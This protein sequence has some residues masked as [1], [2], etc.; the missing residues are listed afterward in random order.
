MIQRYVLLPIQ[1]L[2]LLHLN[3]TKK[4]KYLITLSLLPQY[5]GLLFLKKNPG[6]VEQYYSTG[7]YPVISKLLNTSFK[8][9]PVSLGDLLYIAVFIYMTKWVVINWKRLRTQPR[10]WGLDVLTL[11]SIIYFL[12]H[13]CWGLN[14]YRESLHVTLSLKPTY[15][16]EELKIITS[17]LVLK[18]NSLHLSIAND[19]LQKIDTPYSF[20]KM[21]ALS[22]QGYKRL[23]TEYHIFRHPGQNT[24][25][26]L[27]S[28][29]LT[30][31]GFGGYINPFTLEAQVNS[32]MPKSSMLTTIA[33]EQA[34]QLGYAAENEA[35]FIGF[36]ACIHN[37]DLFY[38]YAGYTFAL[39]YCLQEM[40]RRDIDCYKNTVKS[41]HPGI[42]KKFQETSEFWNDYNNPLEPLIKR[43]YNN[44]LKANNQEKGIKSYSY[45][46]AL[47]VNYLHT[48]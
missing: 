13:L 45:V 48:K 46:V 15:T 35:N 40:S 12:F 3:V 47:L 10:V 43:F 9:S 36:L 38:Q 37:K 41:I 30:Y 17:K 21:A 4:L 25:K 24:K 16:T 28:T 39:R 26:S 8:W 42:L 1:K 27:F 20:N 33:H 11:V 29:P 44:F 19:S 34:H 5:L 22:Q 23:E 6:L 2:K 18:T 32:V 7:F 14:Y 31:M